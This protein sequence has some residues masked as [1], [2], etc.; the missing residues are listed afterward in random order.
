MSK[1][2]EFYFDFGSPTAYLAA[3]QLPKL[4]QKYGAQ[5]EYMPALLGGIFKA[6]NNSAPGL[7]P[8]KGRYMLMHDMPRFIKRYQVP[9]KMN[10]HFPVNTLLPMRGC[11]AAKEMDCLERY[12]T[13]VFD[14]MWVQGLNVSE[15]EVFAEVLSAA[16][17]DAEKLLAL[18][19][20]DSI[21]EQL[22]QATEAAVKRGLFGLPTTFVGK[23]MFFGQDRMD[24]IEEE[25]AS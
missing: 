16:G 24:F 1:N 21:K 11:F 10:P 17:I 7:I 12:I 3:T 18:T 4:A 22:K 23:E 5:I 6:T 20:Q 9:F 2:I 8:N 14:A 13:A 25:L 19:A 15:P